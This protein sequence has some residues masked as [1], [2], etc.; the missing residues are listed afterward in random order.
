[1]HPFR[2]LRLQVWKWSEG[3]FWFQWRSPHEE[4]TTFFVEGKKGEGKT[5]YLTGEACKL[6]RRGVRVCSN[7][8]ITDRLTGAVSVPVAGWLDVLRFSVDA[9]ETQTPTMFVIDEFHLWC[10]SRSWSKTPEWFRGWLAQSRHYGVGICGSVQNFKTVELRARQI[11]DELRRV[12]KVHFFGVPLYRMEEVAPESVDAEGDYS[13]ESA[14]L[15][16]FKWYAGYSTRELIAVEEWKSDA[17]L[18]AEVSA[19]TTR[20]G[21]LVAP[22]SFSSFA[23]HLKWLVQ[24]ADEAGVL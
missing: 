12:R 19:L 20:A 24:S 5:R 16:L 9:L 2:W 18:D 4:F 17:E 22:E 14:H 8:T 23:A 6:M 10:D 13:L 3:L 21:Q 15:G 7:Y 1:M 11:A